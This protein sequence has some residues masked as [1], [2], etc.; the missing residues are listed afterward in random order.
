MGLR[1]G[2][3]RWAVKENPVLPTSKSLLACEES[4]VVPLADGLSALPDPVSLPLMA[5]RGGAMA[6][7]RAGRPMCGT[8]GEVVG[9]EEA[10][11]IGR[12]DRG[13]PCGCGAGVGV[14]LELG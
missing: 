3:V 9:A 2:P 14:D 8:T 12:P 4:V 1:R 6:D 7:P 10:C 11:A 5:E 13:F